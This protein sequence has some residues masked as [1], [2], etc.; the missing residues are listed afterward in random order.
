[1]EMP[2]VLIMHIGFI[3]KALNVFADHLSWKNTKIIRFDKAHRFRLLHI[4]DAG[5]NWQEGNAPTTTAIWS[6][7]QKSIK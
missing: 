3:T 1:M 6:P 5:E 4:R 7:S 2:T